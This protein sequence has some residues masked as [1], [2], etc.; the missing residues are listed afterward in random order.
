M[1]SS[2]IKLKTVNQLNNQPNK[3][4]TRQELRLYIRDKRRLLSALQQEE[5]AK[6]IAEK[7]SAL[8]I[9]R[10]AKK[11]ALYLAN[12]GELNLSYFITWCWQQNIAVYLPVIHPFSKNHLL[13]VHYQKNSDMIKNRFGI[14]EPKLTVTNIIPTKELD[15]LFTPLVAF[16]EQG[17]RLGM[18]GGFYDRTLAY[19]STSCRMIGLA[20]ELQKV[21]QL[22]VESWD[23]PLPEII[24]PKQHYFFD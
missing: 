16:D 7:L 8:S 4:P 6:L 21:A 1:M 10:E 5:S 20:H 2:T 23:I 12:D 17:N 22:P 3:L 11:V 24:T 9:V 13:F 19:L 14:E 18:G 15:I